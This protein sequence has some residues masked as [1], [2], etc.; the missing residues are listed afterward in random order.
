ML[1]A[2]D[3]EVNREGMKGKGMGLVWQGRLRLRRTEGHSVECS[4]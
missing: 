4:T 1:S 3:C 2:M